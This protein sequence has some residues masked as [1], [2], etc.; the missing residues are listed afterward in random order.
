MFEKHD[1]MQIRGGML[2]FDFGSKETF[3]IFSLWTNKT[4]NNDSNDMS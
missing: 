3:K 4:E 1:T 2:L